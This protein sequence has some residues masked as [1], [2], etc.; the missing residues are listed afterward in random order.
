MAPT[1]DNSRK[2]RSATAAVSFG[3]YADLAY[4][5][6]SATNSSPQTTELFSSDRGETLWKYVVIGHV[7]AVVLGVFGSILDRSLWPLFGT[8][9]IGSVMHY[10]YSH[11]LKAGASQAPPAGGTPLPGMGSGRRR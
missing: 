8:L 1:P 2:I 9:S 7:Q 3:V 6:Y 10:M 4:N 11:A 5:L